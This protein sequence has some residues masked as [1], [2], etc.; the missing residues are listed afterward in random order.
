VRNDKSWIT[1]EG[2]ASD[3]VTR[4]RERQLIAATSKFGKWAFDDDKD[5]G[6]PCG[7]SRGGGASP[8]SVAPM[9][10]GA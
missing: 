8:R 10:A 5:T 4:R 6:R 1:V 2:G 7:R 3:H 9:D